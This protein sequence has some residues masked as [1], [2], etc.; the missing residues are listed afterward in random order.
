MTPSIPPVSRLS[1]RPRDPDLLP[2]LDAAY[3]LDGDDATWLTR[4]AEGLRVG[5]DVGFGIHAFFV[6]VRDP[7]TLRIAEPVA[8]GL[9]SEWQA[10]WRTDWWEPF[11]LGASPRVLHAMLTHSP[12]N[13]SVELWRSLATFPEFGPL[14]DRHAAA[15][16]GS[17]RAGA[18]RYPDSL[19]LLA[20]DSTG[21][22]CA[23]AANRD[24]PSTTQVPAALARRLGQLAT[25]IA[26]AYRLRRR[27]SASP[28]KDPLVGSDVVIDARHRVVHAAAEAQGAPAL[29]AIRETA[30]AVAQARRGASDRGVDPQA[31]LDAW[32]ALTAGRWSVLD[33][34][35]R[36]GRR[37]YIARSNAASPDLQDASALE[38][39]TQRERQVLGALALG[40]GNKLIAYE[41]GLHPATVSNH[42]RAAAKKLG[43]SSRLDL[44]RR[45]KILVDA[46]RSS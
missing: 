13:H 12:L 7:D 18:M 11:M 40:H 24:R 5:L 21:L 30:L 37:Y 32:H 33:H 19:N 16:D 27:L 1:K 31:A 25:H 36:D 26:A 42:L 4:I 43:A 35:D 41:L 9:T 39:L 14:F 10:A 45:A 3:V 23:F 15:G 29:A 38:A 2:A 46:Q 28:D 20:L 22:G 17:R 6:D 34:F 8:V 44:A